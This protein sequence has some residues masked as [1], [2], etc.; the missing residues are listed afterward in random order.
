[1]KKSIKKSGQK[2]VKKFSRVSKRASIESK[3]H[4]KENVFKRF[5]HILNIKLLIFEWVLLATA[6]IMLA[7]TQAIWFGNSYAE[8][9]YVSGGT[10]TEA[11]LGKVN[12]L[13]PLFATTSSE[14]TLS[15]LMFSALV[16][17]D[18]SG[19]PGLNLAKT[20]TSSENG[21]VWTLTLKDNLKW[22]DGEPLTLDDVMYTINLI[23]NPL[24]STVYSK[25]LSGTKVEQK[26]GAIVFTLSSVY[27]DFPSVLNFP[28]VP[29]HSLEDTSPQTLVEDEFS[30]EPV[31]SG[32]FMLNATQ[33]NAT[34]T[35]TTIYLSPN[36]N[37]YKSGAM[38]TS[39][40]LRTYESK[41]DLINAVNAGTVSA[42]AE[43]S[44]KEAEKITSSQFIKKESSI[45]WGA[46][47]FINMNSSALKNKDL[48]VAIKKG[49]DFNKI[50]A[51]ASGTIALDYPI[52]DSQIV[53]KNK[54]S[55]PDYNHDGS[56]A[57]I[58]EIAGE[59]PIKLNVATV[60]TGF[61]TE[62]TDVFAEELRSLGFEVDIST[63]DENQDFIANVISHRNYDILIY[64]IELGVDP[65]P[66]AYY[67]S[68][69]ISTS[70]LNLSNYRNALVDDLLVGARETMDDTLRVKKYES[71]LEHW[72]SDIPAIGIYQSNL[73]YI[74]N[75][76][77]RAY[78][79]NVRLVTPFDRFVDV[80][81]WA[82]NKSTKNKTP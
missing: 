10:Y 7:A 2:I 31:V 1:M 76:N 17:N 19:H 25:N 61:L 4:I 56:A 26:E 18:Y 13:N 55:M 8:D 67:H 40:A 50:R 73:T 70:G 52:I 23:K 71:F 44:G 63:Y 45:N 28:I 49:V 6:L 69:Q 72:A 5:S 64:E 58:A 77:V 21:K 33:T 3:E 79:D 47:A 78:G 30:I 65:D 62:V 80:T 14:R 60:R 46:F 57:K 39:F 16:E 42:T 12:S 24:V 68:S 9:A 37:Y 38:L 81:T 51:V 74:Y 20:L 29:K 66:L 15:K 27:A 41:D 54:P 59:K 22:S 82:T 32:P 36:P 34:D 75:K 43:L 11:T 48:R 53:L 35:E